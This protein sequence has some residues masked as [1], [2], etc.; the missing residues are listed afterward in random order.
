M[1]TKENIANSHV[2]QE[3][4][5]TISD[6]KI[7]FKKVKVK[8]NHW[9]QRVL[10]FLFILPKAKDIVLS[11]L[12][13]GTVYRLL[14]ILIDLKA[15]GDQ[16][17][18]EELSIY[19]ILKSNLPLLND[20]IVIGL[21]NSQEEPPKWLYYAV[22]YQ[23]TSK[24]IEFLVNDIY[25]RLDVETF[26]GITASLRKIQALSLTLEAEAPGHS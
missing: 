24:E 13:P 23:L 19:K 20:F 1:N 15:K 11:E 6:K 25:R 26:F 12:Y 5:D 4:A 21:S 9:Y 10:A 18:S 7:L 14:S 8:Y 16:G 2:G 3:V 17:D 22:N